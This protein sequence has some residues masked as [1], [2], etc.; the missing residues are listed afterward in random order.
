ME[1]FICIHGHFYQPPRENPWLEEI[2]IQDSAYPY[3]DWNERITAECYAP[4]SSSRLLD[5]DNR[6]IDIVSNYSKISFDFGP[7]LLLWMQKYSPETY[8]LILEADRQSM[9]W[10][11]GHGNALAQPYNHIIMPL[12]NSRDKRTQVLW[13]I[14][15]FEC[16]YHRYP[17]GMW[18][19]ETAV[20]MET[21]DIMSEFGITFTIL[22]PH[23]AG[24]IRKIGTDTWTDVNRN[25]IDPSMAYICQLPSGRR[26]SIFFY[27][28]PVARAVA[29]EGILANGEEFVSRILTDFSDNKKSK[30]MLNIATDGESYGHHHKFGDMSLAFA[31]HYIESSGLAGLTNYGEYLENNPPLYEVQIHENTSW[32]CVHGI[33]RWKSNCGCNSG[34]NQSGDQEWRTSLREAIDWLRDRISSI[35][36]DTAKEYLKNPWEARDDYVEVIADRSPE[37]MESYLMKHATRKISNADRTVVLKL[38]EMQRHAML[39]YTSCGWFFDELS[40]IETVQIIQYAGRVIQLAQ[41]LSG[42][43]LEEPFKER[44]SKAKSNLAEHQDGASIY[45]KFVKPAIVDLNRVTAHYA[46]SSLIK[47][48]GDTERVYCYQIKKADYQR[49]QSGTAKIA[50][51]HVNVTSDITFNSETVGF[52]ALYL[53]GHV[54]NGAIKAFSGDDAYQLMKREIIK[55]FESGDISDVIRLVDDHFDKN[56]YSLTHLFRDEQRKIL[57]IVSDETMKQFEHAYRILYENNQTLMAFYYESGIPV[58]GP[59]LTAA[60]F[61]LNLDLKKAFSEE[62]IDAERVKGIIDEIKKWNVELDSVNMEFMLR[63]K[64]EGMVNQLLV[65]PWNFSLLS[66]FYKFMEVVHSVPVGVNFW[67][68]QNAYFQIAKTVYTE[69]LIKAKEGNAE[70]AQWIELYRSAGEKLFFN[71]KIVLSD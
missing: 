32:S 31:L 71:T 47:D 5:G 51:G 9:K 29:F 35:F 44:L 20:D 69:I 6:I 70:A 21:L 24:K 42:I 26:M 36:E 66:D 62:E 46:I 60:A 4:N 50:V 22:A 63:R 25:E 57:N 1:R 33:E 19:P 67:Q 2:E 43:D 38:M 56:T 7:T 54:F 30:P 10:R 40:G 8:E 27:H 53:G 12:A 58:P 3:H 37:S 13:G 11:S 15:D 16:R 41:K 55:A 48:Y 61:T 39:M 49:I 68:I 45:D 17:E 65:S 23:Q 28:E 64:G 52:C 18:L 59:F 14:K 34:W